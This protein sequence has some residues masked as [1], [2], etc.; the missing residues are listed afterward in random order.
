MSKM[1]F[2]LS[3]A[4][5][6]AALSA[7]P[8][9]AIAL[10]S[11]SSV[12]SGSA[13]FTNDGNTLTIQ[14]LGNTTI[15][16]NSFYIGIG[17][18]VIFLQSGAQYQV[19]NTSLSEVP[20]QIYGS[21]FSNGGISID[22]PAGIYVDRLGIIDAPSASLLSPQSSV[23]IANSSSLLSAGITLS[24]ATITIDGPPLSPGQF[25]LAPGSGQITIT[26]VPEPETYAMMLAGLSLLGIAARRRNNKR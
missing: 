1:S 9:S 2:R 23:V 4:V 8:I 15:N 6:I 14:T 12:A 10:P 11:F 21:L 26:A 18:A 3:S 17:E 7:A 22:A 19:L 5:V 25:Q 16:W 20:A 24:G 13:S